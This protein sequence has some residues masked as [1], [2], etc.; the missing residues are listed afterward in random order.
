MEVE[1]LRARVGPPTYQSVPALNMCFNMIDRPLDV[2]SSPKLPKNSSFFKKNGHLVDTNVST[3]NVRSPPPIL[4]QLIM[5][6][7]VCGYFSYTEQPIYSFE[8]THDPIKKNICNI[9]IFKHF[10]YLYIVLCS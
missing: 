9:L 1:N 10:K 2:I 6:V 4:K 7:T 5:A 3:S 8:P